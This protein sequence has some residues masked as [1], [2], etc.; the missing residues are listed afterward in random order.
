MRQN[1]VP[2]KGAD[3]EVPPPESP[4][5]LEQ[6]GSDR[7]PRNEKRPGGKPGLFINAS[8]RG[9]IPIAKSDQLVWLAAWFAM[10]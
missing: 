2:P 3:I 1:F 9:T 10:F 4:G 8:P 5:R 6:C 7:T